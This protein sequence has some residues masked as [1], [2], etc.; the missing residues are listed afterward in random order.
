MK[1]MKDKDDGRLL[2][3]INSPCDGQTKLMNNFNTEDTPIYM[4]G[5]IGGKTK[6]MARSK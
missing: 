6:D 4:S 3:P 1:R 5:K 2:T